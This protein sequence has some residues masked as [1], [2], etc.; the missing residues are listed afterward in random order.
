MAARPEG[1]VPKANICAEANVI[2]M[3]KAK[4]FTY[5]FHIR[6]HLALL[7]IPSLLANTLSILLFSPLALF[8]LSTLNFRSF[9]NSISLAA[10]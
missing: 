6:Q 5:C 2:G 10:S 7:H 8:P 9:E 4:S 1:R 3:T